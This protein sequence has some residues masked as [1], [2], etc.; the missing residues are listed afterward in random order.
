MHICPATETMARFT[1]GQ[2]RIGTDYGMTGACGGDGEFG[3][4]GKGALVTVYESSD[5]VVATGS[6]GSAAYSDAAACAFPV[7]VRGVPDGSKSHSVH[8]G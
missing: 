5:K 1:L 6:L 3:D 4:V 8:V 7:V 2:L